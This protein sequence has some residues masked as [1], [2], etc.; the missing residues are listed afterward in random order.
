MYQYTSNSPKI[1]ITTVIITM[2]Q[3]EKE[4]LAQRSRLQAEEQK[5]LV[6]QHL[7]TLDDNAYK[8]Q[9]EIEKIVS[10][11]SNKAYKKLVKEIQKKKPEG[12]KKSNQNPSIVD[13]TQFGSYRREQLSHLSRNQ[14]YPSRFENHYVMVNS[15]QKFKADF[16][17][18]K[19]Q[20]LLHQGDE[21]HYSISGRLNKIR[22][23]GNKLYFLDLWLDNQQ[24]Q[25]VA[26]K[27]Y[28]K[29][30]SDTQSNDF[31]E[32][33]GLFRNGDWIGVNGFVG[34][35]KT[36]EL[37]IFAESIQMLCPTMIQMTEKSEKVDIENMGL[38]DPEIIFRQPELAMISNPSIYD[39]FKK[40]SKI[41]RQIRRY[42]EDLEFDEVETS[43]LNHMATGATAKCF[44]THHNDLGQ[45]MVLR[46]ATEIDL[47]R[48]R[49]GGLTKI[50]EIGRVFRNEGID[51]TH[52]PEFTSLEA[53]MNGDYL[54]MMRL[55]QNLLQDLTK[56]NPVIEYQG[57]TIDFREDFDIIPIIPSLQAEI[58]DFPETDKLEEER[59][60]LSQ[61]CLR[62]LEK[63]PEPA[64]P[65]KLIDKLIGHF[66]EDKIVN[67]TFIV[68]HPKFMC[69]LAKTDPKNP[70]LTQ[71]FELFIMG[72]EIANAYSE[73]NDP[74]EQLERFTE[75]LKDSQAGD[76]E[77]SGEIDHT[78]IE[79]LKIGLPPTTGLGI[80]IDRLV[81]FLTNASNIRQV[82]CFPTLARKQ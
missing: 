18:L 61:I 48:L 35:S 75:Q 20:E 27:M 57:Q 14:L 28:W 81:M 59:E 31:A 34:R 42:F 76:D 58:P 74:D 29:G 62:E 79:S 78:F 43:I 21:N 9:E 32:T 3:E 17:Y 26:N 22:S 53:Y 73:L 44:K 8:T 71:R 60:K 36:S 2:N 68:G 56:E 10:E 16:D 4:A 39:R 66:I 40:R 47:K 45:D 41:I 11:M 13:S 6:Y 70:H 55:T 64:T 38:R 51:L 54:D 12:K 69:P 52:N 50:F 82:I 19:P 37:S 5:K 30:T 63:L 67:P 46:I 72:K 25:I 7:R 77:I 49:V 33:L 65:S 15:I 1:S 80:G 24:I 23:Y